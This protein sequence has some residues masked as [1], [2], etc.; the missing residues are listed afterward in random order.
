MIIYVTSFLL[1]LL[2]SNIAFEFF[3]I[4][5]LIGGLGAGI[6]LFLNI[7]DVFLN[8]NIKVSCGQLR[9]FTMI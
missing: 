9:A 8:Y 3:F 2:F 6:D 1:A 7:Q 5:S 4:G